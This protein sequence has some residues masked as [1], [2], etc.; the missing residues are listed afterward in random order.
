MQVQH[1]SHVEIEI[2]SGN[3]L[4]NGQDISTIGGGDKEIRILYTGRDILKINNVAN[5][6]GRDKRARFGSGNGG[7]YAHSFNIAAFLAMLLPCKQHPGR[8]GYF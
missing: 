1:Q 4:E 6:I 5:A 2:L 7:E 3:F 8:Y